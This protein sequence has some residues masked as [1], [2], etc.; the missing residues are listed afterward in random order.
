MTVDCAMTRVTK[1]CLVTGVAG[2]GA[3]LL[4]CLGIINVGSQVALYITLPVGVTFLGLTLI[5]YALEKE[6][7][8]FDQERNACS[9]VV[10][11][12]SERAAPENSGCGCQQ[13]AEKHSRIF[14][15]SLS[16]LSSD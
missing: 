8:Q 9:K 14:G 3:G 16:Q 1:T 10:P 15:S 4:V 5:C 6:V 7:A 12:Q 2:L 13:G 11:A